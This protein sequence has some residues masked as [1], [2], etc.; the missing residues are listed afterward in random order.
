MLE[1]TNLKGNTWAV[2]SPVNVG[3][4]VKDGEV[5]LIDTG[6]SADAGRRVLKLVREKG[7]NVKW[8]VNTHCHAD[9]IGGKGRRAMLILATFED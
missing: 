6:A 2:L 5:S 3:V 8:I 7:W 1:L 9:H 4:Y